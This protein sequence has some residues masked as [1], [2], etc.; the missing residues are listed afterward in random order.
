MIQPTRRT[1][2]LFASSVPVSLLV[3]SLAESVWYAAFYIPVLVLAFFALDL[4]AA[5]PLKRLGAEWKEPVRLYVGRAGT[6]ELRLDAGQY[7]RAVKVEALPE[8]VGDVDPP[9]TQAAGLGGGRTVVLHLPIVPHRRGRVRVE[10]VWLRWR[11]PLGLVEM[12]RRDPVECDIDVV[13]DIKG[14]HDAALQ[15]FSHDAVYGVKTQKLK[16]EGSE[17]ENLC[18]YQQGMDNRLIDWKH[19][20]RH[21]KLLCK[22]FRRERNHEILMGFDTGHLML[23]PIDGVPRLDHAI[24]AALLLGWI[25]LY[26]GDLIGGCGFDARFRNYLKP[27]RGMPYFTQFQRFAAAL[28]Y[29]TEETNFTLGLAELNARLQRRA[30]VVL[31][32]E[33]VDMI[34][35]ELLIESLQRIARRHVVIFVTMRDP[36]LERLRNAPPEDFRSAAEAVLAGDMERERRIVLERAARMGVH[37]LD[38]ASAV[39]PAALV[40]RYIMIKQRGLL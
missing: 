28:D 40:N 6:L 8:L 38:V 33:F 1:A 4:A 10:A 5:L 2:L 29:R 25:S 24:R 21:R 15:F 17:F 23:E 31:F 22:E 30:L 9:R 27:G 35:A 13:P 36:L 3:V 34:S 14:I 39:V 37:C 32:T 16:G 18:E 19:S 11:G 7:G 12:R 20:A 26:G